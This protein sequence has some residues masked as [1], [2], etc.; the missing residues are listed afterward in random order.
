MK[1]TSFL[2]ATLTAIALFACSNDNSNLSAEDLNYSP[3]KSLQKVSLGTPLYELQA[4]PEGDE[5]QGIDPGQSTINT[6]SR[7]CVSCGSMSVS[8]VPYGYKTW[9]SAAICDF[10]SLPN[11]SWN[12]SYQFTGSGPSGSG[13]FSVDSMY[14]LCGNYYLQWPY[15]ATIT[16][17]YTEAF[18]GTPANVK[19]YL[20]FHGTCV[21]TALGG[22]PCSL[23]VSNIQG[24][25]EY[26]Y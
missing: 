18:A 2:F 3:V 11:P 24:C 10:T 9:S 5:V 4:L 16:N 22:G 17:I 14:V 26:S 20:Q 19:C 25:Q 21:G 15:P 23:T 1:R 8:G 12:I 13:T 7:K 6:N